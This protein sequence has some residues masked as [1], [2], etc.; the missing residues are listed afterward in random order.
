MIPIAVHCK[1]LSKSFAGTPAVDSVDLEVEEGGFLALLGPSGCGKTT[2]LR[3]IAGFET[4]DRG[5]VEI[6]G[7]PVSGRGIFVPP[8]KRRVGIVFQDYALFPH[9]S[10]GDNI[11]YGLNR[12]TDRKSRVKEMLSLVGMRDYQSRMPHELSGGEQQRVAIARAL[13]P[14]PEVLLLDEPFSNLDA[15]LRSRIRSEIKSILARAGATVIFVTHDQE[16]ALFMGD[17]VGVMNRGKLEQLD[18][19]EAIFHT[20][21]TTFVAQFIGT[22]DFLKGQIENGQVATEIGGLPAYHKLPQGTDVRVMI[23]PDFLDITP[24]EDGIGE[25][26]DRIFYGM[27]YIYRVR[28]PSGATI[29]SLQHHTRSYPVGARV[30][31][32]MNSDHRAPCFNESSYVTSEKAST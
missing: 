12:S 15:D 17:R 25:I 29:R 26:V 30:S 5:S 13:A 27:H 24:A 6:A 21:A 23:R 9:L 18:T 2:L 32:R 22:A 3:L 14:G 7:K 31:F 8:E 19:P 28:L 1:E 16:E 20:P 4:P 10:V 11:A